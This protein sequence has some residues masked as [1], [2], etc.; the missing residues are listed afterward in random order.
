MIRGSKGVNPGDG[1]CLDEDNDMTVNHDPDEDLL[2]G[3]SRRSLLGCAAT[4]AA[5]AATGLS[6]PAFAA[7]RRAGPV[8]V[9]VSHDGYGTHVEPCLASNPVDPHNLLGAC[10]VG[11][12][13]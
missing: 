12:S 4:S 7:G 9:R 11:P 10:M 1:T 3:I 5:V 8:N 13:T 6:R 2:P